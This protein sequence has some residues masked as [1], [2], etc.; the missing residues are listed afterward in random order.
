MQILSTMTAFIFSSQIQIWRTC[1]CYSSLEVAI[2]STDYI[3]IY[4][5][6]INSIEEYLIQ[7]SR[8]PYQ[9]SQYWKMCVNYQYY[10]LHKPVSILYFHLFL[11][12]EHLDVPQYVNDCLGTSRHMGVL[13]TSPVPSATGGTD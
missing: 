3:Y 5:Y 7:M 11:D 9:F 12:A 8:D 2:L 13:H 4:I 1:A 10:D 6:I